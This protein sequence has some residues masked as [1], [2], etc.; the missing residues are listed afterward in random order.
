MRSSRAVLAVAVPLLLPS[1]IHADDALSAWNPTSNTTGKRWQYGTMTSL[2]GPLT[3]FTL[4]GSRPSP[5]ADWWSFDGALNGPAIGF[6]GS[7]G[8]SPSTRSTP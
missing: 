4:H 3:L 2:G 6:N 1:A 7:G 5:K 8:R